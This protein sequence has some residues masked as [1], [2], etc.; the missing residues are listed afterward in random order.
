[1]LQVLR[2]AGAARFYREDGGHLGRDG[3]WHDPS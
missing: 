3:A 1:M 2:S